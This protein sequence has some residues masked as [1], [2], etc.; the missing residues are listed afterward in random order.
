MF[1]DLAVVSILLVIGTLSLTSN[2]FTCYIRTVVLNEQ[3]QMTV[4]GIDQG[5]DNLSTLIG[6]AN[7]SF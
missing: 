4:A 1:F 7:E 3:R 6:N 5:I 2:G